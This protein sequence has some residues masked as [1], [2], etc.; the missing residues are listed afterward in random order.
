[1][2][3]I[4]AFTLLALFATPPAVWLI[5]TFLSLMP[6]F[7]RKPV[8]VAVLLCI[9]LMHLIPEPNTYWSPYYRLD[10][11]PQPPM[12]NSTRIPG[13]DLSVNHDFFQTPLDLSPGFMSKYPDFEPNRGNLRY[14]D[15]PYSF[16]PHPTSVLIVG[17]GTGNDVAAAVRHGVEHIDAVEIDPVI[18]ALGRKF[19]PEHP[20]A[21]P[22][23]SVHI[24]DA[25]SFFSKSTDKYDLIVF[26]F[27]DAH[28]LF[29]SFSSLRLDNYVYTLESL[30]AARRLLKPGGTMV[31]AFWAG[32]EF[33][34][35]RLYETLKA[36]FGQA[37]LALKA[38]VNRPEIVFIEGKTPP[39][40]DSKWMVDVS[41]TLQNSTT[42]IPTDSWPFLYLDHRTIPMSLLV[43]LVIV[44]VATYE[45]LMSSLGG[46]WTSNVEYR[47][48][49]FL[50]A[51][52]MLLETKAITQL[53]LLY[54]STWIVNSVVITALL[55][56][57]FLANLWVLTKPVS[58]RLTYLLL[59]IS[60]VLALVISPSRVTAS[61][62]PIK[63]MAAGLLAGVPVFFS[64]IIFSTRFKA[65]FHPERA[66]AVNLFGAI[67][68]GILENAV[69]LGGINTLGVL[70]ILLYGAAMLSSP[71]R[72]PQ[73]AERGALAL[74][75]GE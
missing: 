71:A 21:S 23:V 15:F 57:G 39:T 64:G 75:V 31:M 68:G 60:L 51:A 6:F 66:L 1:M 12:Q 7:W 46:G 30:Q 29:S 62:T 70:A 65:S 34:A 52:F 59:F 22:Q 14:Y 42:T 47:Q 55:A 37:P 2:A 9:V 69:M 32:R 63:A 4:L 38:D 40:I 3:G 58:L 41:T 11:T 33:L 67:A 36:T 8:C 28:T 53:S 13:Y 5:V 10:L 35:R 24:D 16:I 50:G 26:G 54:G 72:V 18:V 27:L 25:R 19:H 48:M 44:I 49:F 45:L 73:Q 43:L 61:S 74:K 56:M 20:Y 17:A